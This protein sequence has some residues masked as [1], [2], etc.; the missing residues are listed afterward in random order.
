M[1]STPSKKVEGRKIEKTEHTVTT[2]YAAKV[3]AAANTPTY[4]RQKIISKG[5]E[6]NEL[7]LTII[8]LAEQ[9]I[10]LSLEHEYQGDFKQT[11]SR[12]YLEIVQL[13]GQQCW[14]R[15]Q[16]KIIATPYFIFPIR[17][18]SLLVSGVFHVPKEIPIFSNW[19]VDS[20]LNVDF[21]LSPE[22]FSEKAEQLSNNADS[23][24]DNMR[25]GGPPFTQPRGDWSFQ[26]SISD[27]ENDSADI[28]R[29]FYET[30]FVTDSHVNTFVVDSFQRLPGQEISR[31]TE[32]DFQPKGNSTRVTSRR[33]LTKSQKLGI[34]DGSL[35]IDRVSNTELKRS[36]RKE[37]RV[38]YIP[39]EYFQKFICRMIGREAYQ[40]VVQQ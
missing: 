22:P 25:E 39:Y 3:I 29:N 37:K 16:W 36:A 17:R 19:S 20:D 12:F 7:P 35:V 14:T 4:W 11:F 32:T 6:N 28:R 9:L 21:L 31:S 10:N 8:D 15:A 33:N 27:V 23:S 26:S 13:Q 34:L 18:A 30:D 1:E 38:N 5:I 24:L 2:Y 40:Q